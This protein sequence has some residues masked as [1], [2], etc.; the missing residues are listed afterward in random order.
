M[1]R[2]LEIRTR[3]TL[4]HHA[5]LVWWREGA[6]LSTLTSRPHQGTN[7]MESKGVGFWDTPLRILGLLASG[8]PVAKHVPAQSGRVHASRLPDEQCGS[9]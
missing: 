1:S 6:E 7:R 3:R 4:R 5:R 2:E 8:D 9:A